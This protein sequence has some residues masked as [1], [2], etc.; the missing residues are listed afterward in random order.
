M[1]AGNPRRLMVGK[2]NLG[3][4]AGPPAGTVIAGKYEILQLLGEGE[5]GISLKSR[6]RESGSTVTLKL[7]KKESA[8]EAEGAGRLSEVKATALTHPNLL[9]I[10][11]SGKDAD[12]GSYQVREYISGQSLAQIIKAKSA[13]NQVEFLDTFKQACKGLAFLHKKKILHGNLK[14]T[15]ILLTD[16]YVVRLV[17]LSLTP[18]VDA[19]TDIYTL[20]WIMY[21]SLGGSSPSAGG[22]SA[23][24]RQL[25]ENPKPFISLIPA[26][27]VDEQVEALIFRCLEKDV[28]RSYQSIE[29]LFSDL[30][31]IEE[32][33]EIRPLSG[34]SAIKA[35]PVII[36]AL[37]VALVAGILTSAFFFARSGS[38]EASSTST[39]GQSTTEDLT[40]APGQDMS[41][42]EARADKLYTQEKYQEA[43]EIYNNIEPSIVSKYGT[44]SREHFRILHKLGRAELWN[45]VSGQARSTYTLLGELVSRYPDLAPRNYHIEQEVYSAARRMF[46]K[47]N[48]RPAADTFD[49]A[50]ELCRKYDQKNEAMQYHIL[51]WIAK[52]HEMNDEGDDA[53]KTFNRAARAYASQIGNPDQSFVFSEYAQ[54]LMRR[55]A[56]ETGESK[57]K[58]LAKAEELLKQAL[59]ACRLRGDKKEPLELNKLLKTV[60]T[61]EGKNSEAGK[62]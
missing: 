24:I 60:Y 23:Q 62:L 44:E 43:S 38:R 51:I 11:E 54:M 49:L 61:S 5:N 28:S 39:P 27:N 2:K 59:E 22:V 37:A 46:S 16:D 6:Q 32:G 1:I 25:A 14:P 52:C 9:G 8:C 3:P 17:D 50:H 7:L 13:L 31:R 18:A 21:E 4:G 45:E 15:N 40:R 58:T 48:Y 42:E 33:E 29:A 36:A 10:L 26:R 55:A 41:G 30:K 56:N 57:T 47:G 35:K 12:W 19:L 53:E 20:G 34:Q